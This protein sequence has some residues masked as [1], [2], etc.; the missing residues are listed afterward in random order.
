MYFPLLLFQNFRAILFKDKGLSHLYLDNVAPFGG[1]LRRQMLAAPPVAFEALGSHGYAAVSAFFVDLV[2]HF[3][4]T[5]MLC[6]VQLVKQG[7]LNSA[8]GHNFRQN[9][10][11]FFVGEGRFEYA[12]Q[13][14]QNCPVD[15][16]SAGSGY[17][18]SDQR[19]LEM[20]GRLF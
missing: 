3:H 9:D 18:K 14:L 7:T 16:Q 10:A 19:A 5:L 11:G 17:L 8:V 12:L 20:P 2:H 15:L 6:P 4:Q 13:G 1:V